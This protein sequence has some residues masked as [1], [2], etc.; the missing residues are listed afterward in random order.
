M[1][2]PLAFAQAPTITPPNISFLDNRRAP[3]IQVG[4]GFSVLVPHVQV[5]WLGTGTGGGVTSTF[6][7][8]QVM[9]TLG[10]AVP[11][12]TF[13]GGATPIGLGISGHLL[14]PTEGTS[15]RNVTAGGF[16]GTESF[17][18]GVAGDLLLNANFDIRE[19]FFETRVPFR[20]TELFA[21]VGAAFNHF[22]ASDVFPAAADNFEV[23]HTD[24]VPAFQVGTIIRLV[25]GA[26]IVLVIKDFLPGTTVTMPGG[27]PVSYGTAK[28]GNTLG[29]TGKVAIPLGG[30]D[31]CPAFD[32]SCH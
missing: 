27:G 28:A 11:L 17:K 32:Q 30:T 10:I 19:G 9:P 31:N 14:I 16:S 29:F 3:E 25:G 20:D 13:N 2:A 26:S 5:G 22:R 12:T 23:S 8:A 1:L 7:N 24:V 15:T 18:Q 4:A 6:S 21:G